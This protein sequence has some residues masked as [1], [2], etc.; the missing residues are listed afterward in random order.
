MTMKNKKKLRSNI[1]FLNDEDFITWRFTEDKDLELLWNNYINQYPELENQFREAIRLF[2]KLQSKGDGLDSI[3]RASLLSSIKETSSKA[4]KRK[5]R[6][7]LFGRYAA[8]A[9]VIFLVGLFTIF[10]PINLFDY[11]SADDNLIIGLEESGEDILLVTASGTTTFQNDLSIHINR[12]GNIL[13][14]QSGQTEVSELLTENETLNK[15]VVPYGKR[16]QIELSD[17]TKIWLNSGSILEFPT[18]FSKNTREI[19]LNG[20]IYIEVAKDKSKPFLVHSSD[21]DVRVYG[22][23]FNVSTYANSPTSVVLVEG[24]VGVKSEKLDEVYIQPNE[25]VSLTNNS[26]RKELVDVSQYISWKDGYFRFD[27]API[28]EVLKQIGR[29]YNIT[30]NAGNSENLKNITCT[31]KIYLSPDVNNVMQAIAILSSTHYRQEGKTI[32]FNLE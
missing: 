29:Y 17:G 1:E 22:T 5:K 14:A 20:E 21:I 16:S 9:C 10:K 25:R 12:K 8:A 3:T 32:Y 31:G 7:R 19:N 2:S 26:F 23:K 11:S 13:V 18:D 28:T 6:V 15:L 4:I 30:F 27:N 24:S